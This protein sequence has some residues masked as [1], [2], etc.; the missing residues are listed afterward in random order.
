MWRSSFTLLF[1]VALIGCGAG[2]SGDLNA[3][4]RLII[5]SLDGRDPPDGGRRGEAVPPAVGEFHGY[6]VL[7]R[8]EILDLDQRKQLIAA[9][10]EGIAR[11]PAPAKCFWPRHGIQ[12]VENG[13]TFEYVICFQCSQFEEFLAGKRVRQATIDSGVQPEFDKPLTERRIPIAPK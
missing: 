3:P 8:V 12:A 9:L 4:E 6:P 2:T 1:L 13:K 5:F 7:G 10:K 11:H